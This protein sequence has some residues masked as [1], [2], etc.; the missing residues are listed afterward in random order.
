MK[1]VIVE[2]TDKYGGSTAISGGVVWIPNNPQLPGK[3][4]QGLA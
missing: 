3:G 4:I 1:V 2:A